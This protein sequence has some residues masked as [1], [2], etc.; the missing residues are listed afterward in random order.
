MA[1]SLL[2]YL[3]VLIPIVGIAD[4]IKPRA[5]ISIIIDDIGYYSEEGREMIN[6]PANLTY[7]VLPNA[8]KTKQLANL[9]HQQGKE[10]MLHMPMQS[11]LGD[12]SEQGMLD[13]DMEEK[14]VVKALQD[15]FNNVPHAMGMNNH[16]GSLLTRHPGHMTWV[17]KAMREGGYF[18]VDSRTSSKS[19]AEAIAHEQGV[20][21]VKRDV[22][23]DHE[24]DVQS[25]KFEF[26]RLIQIAKRKGHAVGIGHPHSETLAVLREML[27][28]LEAL[29]IALVPISYQINGQQ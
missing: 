16:Q 7:A 26:N 13:I 11:T 12:A 20:P 4:E 1:K 9:A 15:A 10:V 5:V 8:P 28:T 17:M 22:F 14:V 6:L 3:F 2:L 19:V 29:D 27:P 23:L 18:F 25:I 21:V 24:V